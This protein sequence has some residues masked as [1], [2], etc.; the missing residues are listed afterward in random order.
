MHH[1]LTGG[2]MTVALGHV[3]LF[4]PM[5]AAE[6]DLADGHALMDMHHRRH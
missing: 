1:P 6:P 5:I 3:V 4:A 2:G